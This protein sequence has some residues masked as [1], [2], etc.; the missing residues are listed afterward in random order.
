MPD[1]EEVED[2]Y[3]S[4]D[5]Q[6]PGGAEETTHSDDWESDEEPETIS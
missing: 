4:V 2:T 1:D 3:G 5:D 6:P